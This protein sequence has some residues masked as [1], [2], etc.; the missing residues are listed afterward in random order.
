MQSL[1]VVI[2]NRRSNGDSQCFISN[3]FLLNIIQTMLDG[4]SVLH[5]S[6]VQSRS[7]H[8]EQTMEDVPASVQIRSFGTARL[9]E[10]FISI[11]ISV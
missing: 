10:T 2:L 3:P 7:L 1:A 8:S 4:R 5:A 11:K 6:V 9:K